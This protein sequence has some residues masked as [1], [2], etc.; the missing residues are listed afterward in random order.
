M[1]N[2]PCGHERMSAVMMDQFWAAAWYGVILL[3]IGAFHVGI[4]QDIKHEWMIIPD[5]PTTIITHAVSSMFMHHTNEHWQ[6]NLTCLVALAFPSLLLGTRVLILVTAMAVVANIVAS[7]FQSLTNVSGSASCG[8][9][10]LV[11]ALIGCCLWTL[12]IRPPP[13]WTLILRFGLGVQVGLVLLM[14]L[15]LN[16]WSLIPSDM[17]VTG[18]NWIAH[19]SGLIG[20]IFVGTVAV[21]YRPF[22]LT[23]FL[24]VWWS[25]PLSSC[26][27]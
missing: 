24:H 15:L 25:R 5:Q 10:V 16:P 22:L 7:S 4:P 8:A 11:Y 27:N 23:P 9:S 20:G 17:S 19:W 12:V 2:L 26:R 14:G 3:A 21:R 6:A 18:I 13:R 1:A